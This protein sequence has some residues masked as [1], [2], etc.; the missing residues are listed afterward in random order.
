[1]LF[2]LPKPGHYPGCADKQRHKKKDHD[3][4]A[5]LFTGQVKTFDL[6]LFLIKENPIIQLRQPI[7]DIKPH[8]GVAV[9]VDKNIC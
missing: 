3:N 4:Y 6:D 1:M 8:F 7:D 5:F 2:S 9:L